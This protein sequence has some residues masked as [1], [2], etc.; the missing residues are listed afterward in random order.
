M[1]VRWARA[2]QRARGARAAR[3]GPRPRVNGDDPAPSAAA[4]AA[5]NVHREHEPVADVASFR[6]MLAAA[7]KPGES[8]RLYV[9]RTSAG[10]AKEYL[11]L[12]KPL[13]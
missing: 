12:E 1:R 9:Q 13:P 5:K 7:V 3:R 8:V 4:G 2:D 11:V 10:G 6:R